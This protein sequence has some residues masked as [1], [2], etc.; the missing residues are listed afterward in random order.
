MKNE[1]QRQVEEFHAKFGHPIGTT[2]TF[3][4]PELRARLIVEEAIETAVGLLGSSATID[5]LRKELFELGVKA[6]KQPDI[7]EAA[8][9][10]C[11]LLYVTFG[12]GAEMGIDL[13]AVFDEV[14]ASNMAK[15]G[16]ATRADGKTLKPEGWK[17]PAVLD[18]L[19]DQGYTP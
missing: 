15:V 2:P 16:G 13:Q 12:S 17:P 7:V 19:V 10:M 4:R 9:G 3:S 1:M 6:P 11:D 14:H 18:R 5:L 8:D